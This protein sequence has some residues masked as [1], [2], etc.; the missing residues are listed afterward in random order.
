ME[1][2]LGSNSSLSV[3]ADALPCVLL[4]YGT[5]FFGPSNYDWI[6]LAAAIHLL[7]YAGPNHLTE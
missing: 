4:G 3:A 6:G 2:T 1:R 5:S 7:Y